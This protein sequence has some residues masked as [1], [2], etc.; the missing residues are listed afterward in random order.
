MKTI[1]FMFIIS[2]LVFS[3]RTV[4]GQIVVGGTV[5]AD[6]RNEG[7]Y[8]EIAPKIGYKYN[9]FESGLAPFVSYQENSN[10]LTLGLQIYTQATVYK[11]VF[12]HGEFQAA[13]VYVFSESNRQWVLGLPV[14]VGYQYE[15]SKGM[16]A[17]GSILYDFLYKDGFSPQ[18]NPI[19]RFGISY[20]L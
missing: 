2:V 5:S 8:I 6:Y 12:I 17:K 4:S 13:N 19:I 9:I 15:I 16:W 20:T 11:G 1:R 7:Y 3:A 18:K 10:Y 14:G